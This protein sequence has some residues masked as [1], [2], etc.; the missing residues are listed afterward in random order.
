M[1]T[2]PVHLMHDTPPRVHTSSP[3]KPK[4]MNQGR[5]TSTLGPLCP[6]QPHYAPLPRPPPPTILLL[7]SRILHGA[8]PPPH[9]V[10][11]PHPFT[12]LLGITFLNPSLEPL[13]PP[14][15]HPGDLCCVSPSACSPKP[16]NHSPPYPSTHWAIG[17]LRART[18]PSSSLCSRV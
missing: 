18:K 4:P 3:I 1:E 9:P 8:L 10:Y 13:A 6:L 16:Y 15:A 11:L 2:Q 5:K 14:Q 17:M 12:H 7:T